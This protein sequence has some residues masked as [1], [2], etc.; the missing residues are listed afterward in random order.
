[1]EEQTQ[2]QPKT[3]IEVTMEEVEKLFEN[4]NEKVKLDTPAENQGQ[5]DPNASQGSVL[6]KTRTW[7]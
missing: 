4:E 7:Y 6:R 5:Q 2:N 1:M 3:P